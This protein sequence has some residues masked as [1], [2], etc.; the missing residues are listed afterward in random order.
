MYIQTEYTWYATPKY[1]YWFRTILER[2]SK[3][4]IRVRLPLW[5]RIFWIFVSLQSPLLCRGVSLEASSDST[6]ELYR[7]VRPCGVVRMSH[8]ERWA[9]TSDQGR[10]L[11]W[12]R[13]IRTLI[14]STR[15][16]P[17]MIF[18]CS[19]IATTAAG[20]DAANFLTSLHHIRIHQL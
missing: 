14:R 13:V 15:E 5:T 1:Q 20:D 3:K 16:A 4:K 19:F 7:S 12:L 11:Q 9:P 6:V 8:T 18:E 10:M 17:C 2:F